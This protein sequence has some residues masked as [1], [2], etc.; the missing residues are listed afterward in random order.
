MEGT[1]K[2]TREGLYA[3]PSKGAVE[4]DET[5]IWNPRDCGSSSCRMHFV[6]FLQLLEAWGVAVWAILSISHVCALLHT[7]KW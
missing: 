3:S 2:N 4:G 6:C 7:N 1:W 5:P